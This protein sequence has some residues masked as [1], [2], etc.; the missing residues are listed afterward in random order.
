MFA[1]K[2]WIPVVLVL[3]GM[4]IGG[5]FWY[6]YIASQEPTNRS[7]QG[8]VEQTRILNLYFP[9]WTAEDV[10][11][12][13]KSIRDGYVRR[14]TYRYPKCRAYAAI[15]ADAERY[16]EWYIANLEYTKISNEA[17]A[18]RETGLDALIQ[19]EIFPRDYIKRVQL[20]KNLT[21]AEKADL[22]AK[23]IAIRH[24]WWKRSKTA[25]KRREEI[26]QQRPIFQ[27]KHRH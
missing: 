5:T 27:P 11:K 12:Y 7:R 10:R 2:I 1:K 23:F 21:D 26:E 18:R 24:D 8:I 19:G 9:L 17:R 14:H 15:L 6:Q 3:I 25:S 13:I 22:F 16:A 20:W 4:A